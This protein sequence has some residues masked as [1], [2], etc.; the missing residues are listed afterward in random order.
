MVKQ[1]KKRGKKL[2][3]EKQKQRGKKKK[4]Q[5]NFFFWKLENRKTKMFFV[6]F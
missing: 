6:F 1:G 2:F 5:T 4:K 3:L